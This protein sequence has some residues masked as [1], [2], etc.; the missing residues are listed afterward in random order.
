MFKEYDTFRL[1]RMIT[2]D[3]SVPLGT[4]GVVLIVLNSFPRVY[5]VE[6]PDGKGGNLGKEVTYTVSEDFMEVCGL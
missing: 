6:F 2:N 5:E 3:D 4:I 1:K